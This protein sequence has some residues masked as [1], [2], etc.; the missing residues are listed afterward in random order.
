MFID[1]SAK[2]LGKIIVSSGE[3]NRSNRLD[4]EEL[5]KFINAQFH[6]LVEE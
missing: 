6:D 1:Y 5:A 3:L 4:S 2:T